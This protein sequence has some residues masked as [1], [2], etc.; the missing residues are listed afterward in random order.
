MTAETIRKASSETTA[1]EIC[2]KM[3]LVVRYRQLVGKLNAKLAQSQKLSFSWK[4]KLELL[5]KVKHWKISAIKIF[6]DSGI[7]IFES[8]NHGVFLRLKNDYR[9]LVTEFSLSGETKWKHGSL[10][11][12]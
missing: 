11:L 6:R 1:A 9:T 2:D 7:Y 8:V 3:Y 12:I 4:L 10:L 5:Y